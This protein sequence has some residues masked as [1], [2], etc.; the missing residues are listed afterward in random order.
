MFLGQMETKFGILRQRVQEIRGLLTQP[1]PRPDDPGVTNGLRIPYDV[2][3]RLVEIQ[4]RH[5]LRSSKEA[6]YKAM[7]LGLVTLERL[8][9]LGSKEQPKRRN[10]RALSEDEISKLRDGVRSRG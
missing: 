5:G 2:R 4:S 10:Y 3:D 8:E 1:A 6:I 7:L 9:P